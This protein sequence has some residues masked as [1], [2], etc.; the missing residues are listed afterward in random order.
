MVPF[1]DISRVEVFAVHPE[2][3]PQEN[4]R[5]PGFRATGND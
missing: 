3:K 1:E 2:D 4:L 5:I